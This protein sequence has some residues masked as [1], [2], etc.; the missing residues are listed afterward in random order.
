VHLPRPVSDALARLLARPVAFYIGRQRARLEPVS[1]GLPPEERERL[2]PYFAPDLLDRVRVLQSENLG[3]ADPPFSSAVRRAGLEF[4]S[5][6]LTAAI[7]FDDLIAAREPAAGSLLFHEL[8]HVVQ[9][10]VL[11]VRQF[12]RLYVRGFLSQGSYEDIPLERCAYELE[13]RFASREA[14]FP[15]EDEVDSWMRHG[16]F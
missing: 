12:S 5:M 4:P 6:A 14:P 2:G 15:V 11:G 9:F 8:V 7:T 3:I 10:R 1:N 16:R 13:A